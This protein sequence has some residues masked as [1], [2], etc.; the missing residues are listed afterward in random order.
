MTLLLKTSVD[1]NHLL[2]CWSMG[3]HYYTW[4]W[5]CLMDRQDVTVGL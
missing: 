1:R 4:Q 3:E 5:Q 2:L